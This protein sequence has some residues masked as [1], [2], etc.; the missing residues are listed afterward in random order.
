MTRPP[1]L[2]ARIVTARI[3]TATMT[4]AGLIFLGALSGC[5]QAPKAADPIAGK[6]IYD[7]NCVVCHGP[8]GNVRQA[9]QHDPKTPDLRTIAE[10]SPHGRIPRVMLAEIIDGRRIVQAHGSR[11]MPIW[12]EALTTEDSA[13]VEDSINALVAYIESIQV[14]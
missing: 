4:M 2:T 10:R 14:K 12:G 11:T 13:T 6:A 3:A 7:Q 8:D 1:L 5:E 9:A